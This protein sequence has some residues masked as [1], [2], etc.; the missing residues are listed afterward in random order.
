MPVNPFLAAVAG[1][2]VAVKVLPQERAAEFQEFVTRNGGPSV[3]SSLGGNIP[4]LTNLLYEN[5]IVWL[6]QSAPGGVVPPAGSRRFPCKNLTEVLAIQA[7]QGLKRIGLI[8]Q[9]MFTQDMQGLDF[10]GES[11][12]FCA[13]GAA[14]NLG[15]FSADGS[16][17][18]RCGVW[19]RPHLA[20]RDA[21]FVFDGMLGTD[22][23]PID[24]F[25]ERC[26]ITSALPTIVLGVAVL[27]N[28]WGG[29]ENTGGGVGA[30]PVI[31]QS[32]ADGNSSIFL[33]HWR[34][35]IRITNLAANEVFEIEGA[36]HLDI[37]ASCV[38]GDIYIRGDMTYTNAGAATIHDYTINTP[39]GAL[40]TRLTATRAGYLDN[41]Q[42]SLIKQ[43]Q[44]P[45]TVTQIGAVQNTWY[46]LLPTTLN[47]RIYT[48]DF[49]ITD[50]AE[51]L[52][53]RITIDGQIIS[54]TEVTCNVGETWSLGLK[55]D[56]THNG[57][58]AT[59][60]GNW[61]AMRAYL[62]EGRSIK[63]EM[64]KTTANGTGNLT[65]YCMYTKL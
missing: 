56:A 29:V 24:C 9:P 43:V 34:G 53:F 7:K 49:T 5:G 39:I 27:S 16:Y 60:N 10:F 38:G 42:Y 19:G 31:M 2:L 45:I 64:R 30:Q 65:G 41:L 37:P 40:N 13:L 6:D 58:T 36:G 47:A 61:Q 48:A 46:T 23:N 35:N 52:E 54:W 28:C 18:E 57:L 1:A 59:K 25:C 32:A 17:F 51:S 20:T 44:A 15:G 55:F 11:N 3:V 33:R 26:R 63:I 12:D 14:V 8:D 22:T 4:Y 50:T 62:I 21:I